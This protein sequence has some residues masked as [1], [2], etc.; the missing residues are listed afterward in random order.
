MAVGV[1]GVAWPPVEVLVSVVEELLEGAMLFTVVETEGS[2]DGVTDG[3]LPAVRA[4]SATTYN[5]Y[6]THVLAP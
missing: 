5:H 4:Q 3:E 1:L 2:G 6:S